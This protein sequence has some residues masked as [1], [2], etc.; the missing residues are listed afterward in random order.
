M[1]SEMLADGMV[2]PEKQ[3][4]YANTLKVQ[5]DRLSHLVENVLQFAR[6]ERGPAKVMYETVTVDD[7]LAGFRSRLEE[8][9]ADSQMQLEIEVEEP[10]S[11]LPMATQPAAI[12]Q[13]LFNLVD[14]ACKYAQSSTDRRIVISVCQSRNRVQFCVQ[15]FGPGIKP[16][17][18]K[19]MFQPF[20]QSET[21][22]TN[23]VSGVGLGLAL[24]LRMASTLGGRL[25]NK[26]CSRGA[27]FVLE[28]P[29]T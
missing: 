22:T 17:D 19:R 10:L 29:T 24:C 8:R 1:Y 27:R 28:L 3:Q 25:Y 6:L 15:D 14:N 20:Q 16:V 4:Q 7:L 11:K 2:P 23:A 12:E 13:I 9:A 26:E 5:A 21:A 18:R